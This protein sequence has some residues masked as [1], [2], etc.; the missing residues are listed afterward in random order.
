MPVCG[1]PDRYDAFDPRILTVQLHSEL[2]DLSPFEGAHVI[3]DFKVIDHVYASNKTNA[4]MQKSSYSFMKT[5]ACALHAFAC[6]VI[7]D[8]TFPAQFSDLDDDALAIGEQLA[9]K[10]NM[11]HIHSALFSR[12]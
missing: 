4:S 2:E 9:N 6:L 7:V 11:S 12:V 1:R 3:D 8:D 10:L 5:M